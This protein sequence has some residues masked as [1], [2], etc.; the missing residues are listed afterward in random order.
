MNFELV[1]SE[2]MEFSREIVDTLTHNKC[3]SRV[4]YGMGF[5]ILEAGSKLPVAVLV[6]E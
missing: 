5:V 6:N 1:L 2:G 3:L 4:L